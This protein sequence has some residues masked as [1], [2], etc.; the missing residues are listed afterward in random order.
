MSVMTACAGLF[1]H[2]ACNN[3]A[4]KAVQDDMG[5]LSRTLEVL[6]RNDTRCADFFVRSHIRIGV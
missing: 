2:S 6:S 1:S 3:D 5:E 4:L